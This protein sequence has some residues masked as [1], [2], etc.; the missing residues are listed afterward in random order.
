MSLKSFWVHGC[1]CQDTFLSYEPN[2]LWWKV[3]EVLFDFGCFDVGASCALG[4]AC[5]ASNTGKHFKRVPNTSEIKLI[6]F[7][8]ATFDNHYHCS[9]VSTRHYR[10]P[11]VILGEIH[12]LFVAFQSQYQGP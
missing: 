4:W 3:C 11:E 12:G 2:R 5:Q 6:D 10:A 1:L 7:G 9:V 8:S